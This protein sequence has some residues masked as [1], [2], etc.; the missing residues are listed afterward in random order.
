AGK[1]TLGALIFFIQSTQRFYEPIQ[2]ISEKYNILQSAMASSE[3]I[4][5]LLDTPV[6]I[7]SPAAPRKLGNIRGAVEFRNVW[8][9]YNDENWVLK[10]VSFKIEQ[11]ESI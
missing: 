6:S 10:D 1:L 7:T 11:G 2:D 9:A 5:K 4:F 8:F 3:R